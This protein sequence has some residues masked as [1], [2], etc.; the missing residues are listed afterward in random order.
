MRRAREKIHCFKEFDG[1]LC[2]VEKKQKKNRRVHP[3]NG[4]GQGGKTIHP[5]QLHF[6]FSVLYSPEKKRCF[7]GVYYAWQVE[8]LM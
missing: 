8:Q 3:G 6:F 1:D 5:E 4:V 7:I 2:S